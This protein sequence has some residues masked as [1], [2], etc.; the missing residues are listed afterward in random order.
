MSDINSP[1]GTLKWGTVDKSSEEEFILSGVANYGD[2]QVRS[3]V[4]KDTQKIFAAGFIS[5]TTYERYK[6]CM[7]K[8][9]GYRNTSYSKIMNSDGFV[10][11]SVTV[12]S[13]GTVMACGEGFNTT[14]YTKSHILTTTDDWDTHSTQ[15]LTHTSNAQMG[16]TISPNGN[17]VLIPFIDNI[18]TFY[19]FNGS[20]YVDSGVTIS[21]AGANDFIQV[22]FSENSE[23]FVASTGAI[24]RVYSYDYDQSTG[25]SNV[26]TESN[27]QTTADFNNAKLSYDALYTYG[28][29]NSSSPNFVSISS[30]ETS[31]SSS[32]HY[33]MGNSLYSG[34][35]TNVADV[36]FYQDKS[37]MTMCYRDVANNSIVVKTGEGE[38]GSIVLTEHSVIPKAS[39]PWGNTVT[40]Y[41]KV[42]NRNEL[43]VFADLGSSGGSTTISI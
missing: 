7:N 3:A 1:S 32:S 35:G 40:Y 18:L 36:E 42:K 20:T 29:T 17:I 15:T 33:V 9:K 11:K 21:M 19:Y 30:S 13:A 4:A 2:R 23:R 6:L 25:I 10:G 24:N 26:V 39:L 16:P 27:L 43:I 31:S 37:G 12:N 5:Q 8:F 41:V 34:G 28:A 38:L 14:W 22:N